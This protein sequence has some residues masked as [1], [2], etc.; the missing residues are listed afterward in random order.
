MAAHIQLGEITVEV[1]Q[2]DIKNL[3]LSVHPP[4]GRVRISAPRRL[5][6]EAVREFA[7]SKLGWIQKQQEK[8]QA[9]AHEKQRSMVDQASRFVWGERCLLTVIESNQ[10]P[11]VELRQNQLLVRLRPGTNAAKQEAI[12]E[13]WYRQQLKEALPPLIARWEARMGVQVRR[14]YVRRMKTRWGSCNPRQRSVRF[15]TELAKKAPEC[16]EYLVVHEL[17]HLLE[18]SHNARFKALMDR[19]MPGWRLFKEEL[20]RLPL[21]FETWQE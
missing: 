14:F 11:L 4:D 10:L 3:H 21:G 18:P 12:L 20:N 13:A 6:L 7:V 5:A 8:I 19:F 1:V 2:K 16:L 15:N 9:Q 17:A